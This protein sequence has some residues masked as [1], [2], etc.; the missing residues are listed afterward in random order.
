MGYLTWI[1]LIKNVNY[2]VPS[3]TENMS[4]TLDFLDNTVYFL[5]VMQ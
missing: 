3:C 4:V 5:Q 2:K 1:W